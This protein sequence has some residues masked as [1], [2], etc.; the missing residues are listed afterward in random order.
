LT[1]CTSGDSVSTPIHRSACGRARWHLFEFPKVRNLA[2]P[3]GDVV[4]VVHDGEPHAEEWVA[5]LRERG[6][7]LEPLVPSGSELD[8]A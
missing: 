7:E 3:Y 6:I 2:H 5:L 1:R 4:A 8:P